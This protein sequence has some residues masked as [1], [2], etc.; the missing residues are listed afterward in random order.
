MKPRVFLSH[1]KDNKKIIEKIASDLRSARVDVWY[2]EWE[3][4]PGDSFRR[5]ITK[6]ID[7]SDLFFIYLTDSSAKSYWVQHELDTAFVKQ[8]NSGRN[9]LALFVDS[10]QVRSQLPTDLQA[11]HSPVF[12]DDDYLR[13][14]CQLISRGWESYSQRIVQDSTSKSRMKQLEL[15]NEIKT[16]ELTIARAS[17]ADFAD[18]QKIF[19]NLEN[20]K[21]LI[22]D[23]EVTL[24]YVFKVLSNEFAT[25]AHIIYL[26]RLLLK[27]LGLDQNVDS[28]KA[29]GIYRIRDL[30]GPLV[31]L[32]LVYIQPPHGELTDDYYYLTE[33]GKKVASNL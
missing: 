11:I 13:P 33:M 5:Q 3:I 30:I 19:S 28:L 12:N 2:D 27:D 15:E 26:E 8:G 14:L 25:S 16:L 6:G 22:A 20:R 21:F 18:I 23:K 24:L 4:P 31:I 10:D 17:S 32:G 1:S 7:E 29:G 9:I